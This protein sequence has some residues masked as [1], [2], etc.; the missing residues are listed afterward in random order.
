ML[1]GHDVIDS[2]VI[3][4]HSPILRTLPRRPKNLIAINRSGF[5]SQPVKLR[6][7]DATPTISEVLH[8]V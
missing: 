6:M 8:V 4:G 5:I 1:I 3:D 7:L 2:E